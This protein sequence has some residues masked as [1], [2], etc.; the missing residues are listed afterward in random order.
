[1]DYLVFNLL[2]VELVSLFPNIHFSIFY[3]ISVMIVLF[4]DEIL[5]VDFLDGYLLVNLFFCFSN[6]I[7]HY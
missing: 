1:M 5:E 6:I 4:S 3:L 7:S 2:E